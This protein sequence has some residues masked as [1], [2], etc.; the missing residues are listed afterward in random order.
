MP[1]KLV[2]RYIVKVFLYTIIRLFH[3]KDH[4]NKLVQYFH[5]F[6]LLQ[7]WPANGASTVSISTF[8]SEELSIVW[9]RPSKIIWVMWWSKY[10]CC[11]CM[12]RVVYAIIIRKSPWIRKLDQFT[13][14]MF[15]H[16]FTGVHGSLEKMEK[17]RSIPTS[18]WQKGHALYTLHPACVN[19]STIKPWW[20]I[21]LIRRPQQ[22][23]NKMSKQPGFEG[24]WSPWI[25]I[26]T[27]WNTI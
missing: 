5:V 15:T 8:S 4:F 26:T 22:K 17:N 9:V 6:F 12:D 19:P 24:S 27:I 14:V 21:S 18:Q 10:A 3:K 7:G 23:W 16:V 25:N 1:H 11:N 13:V 20:G 2:P